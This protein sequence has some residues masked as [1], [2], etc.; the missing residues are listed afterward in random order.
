[1]STHPP[2]VLVDSK[3]GVGVAKHFSKY[4]D[5]VYDH[6]VKASS[7]FPYYPLY[8]TPVGCPL[9]QVI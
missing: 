8:T 9:T 6:G 5:K 4:I 1:M 3:F 7:V 2:Q